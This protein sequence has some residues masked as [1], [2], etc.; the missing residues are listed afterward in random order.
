[1]VAVGEAGSGA[2]L[3][4]ISVQENNKWSQLKSWVSAHKKEI[5]IALAVAGLAAAVIGGTIAIHSAATS[6]LF[7]GKIIHG[8]NVTSPTPAF[9]SMMAGLGAVGGGLMLAGPALGALAYQKF[10]AR[11]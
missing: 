3:A 4:A 2:T 1:M 8:F 6:S 11:Q 7:D 10:A 9:W 5:L